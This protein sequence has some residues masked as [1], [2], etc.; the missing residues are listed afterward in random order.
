MIPKDIELLKV[1]MA[2]Q[3]ISARDL[4]RAVGWA[5]ATSANRLLAGEVRT[6][7]PAI[8]REIARLLKVQ[9]SLLFMPKVSQ[10]SRHSAARRAS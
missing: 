9:P 7:N 8:A 4:A 5:S 3:G 10:N 1:L 6:V 2:S